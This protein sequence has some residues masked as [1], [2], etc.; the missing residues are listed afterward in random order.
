[1]SEPENANAQE[2]DSYYIVVD[3]RGTIFAV[4]CED[5]FISPESELFVEVM[6]RGFVK[7]QVL[8]DSEEE[9]E[10]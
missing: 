8:S 7:V 6:G 2:Q 9:I 4:P 1:M 5:L 10:N 3:D